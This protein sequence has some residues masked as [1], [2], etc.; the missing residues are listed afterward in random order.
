ME[1]TGIAE[2]FD[3]DLFTSHNVLMRQC[4]VQYG[5]T[6]SKLQTWNASLSFAQTSYSDTFDSN[7]LLHGLSTYR[8]WIVEVLD[9]Y[10]SHEY[11]MFDIVEIFQSED[12]DNMV[13]EIE[14]VRSKIQQGISI[15]L[16]A[17]LADIE[18]SLAAEYAAGFRHMS[19]LAVYFD[20]K[21]SELLEPVRSMT[22]WREPQASLENPQPLS[23]HLSAEEGLRVLPVSIEPYIKAEGYAE[24]DVAIYLKEYFAELKSHIAELDVYLQT[25]SKKLEASLTK[26]NKRV[27]DFLTSSQVGASFIK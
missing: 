18:S 11:N 10:A 5:D 22:I 13:A 15:P 9:K 1:A 8:E 27:E 25:V 21:T 24:E 4:L 19:N 26:M 7:E 17:A 6:L 2:D 12:R 16:T 3:N 20:E 23:Y 14:S